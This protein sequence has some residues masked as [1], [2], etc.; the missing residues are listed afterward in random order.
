MYVLS[1]IFRDCSAVFNEEIY[2]NHFT[3]LQDLV[4]KLC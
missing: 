1:L 3:H 2:I 4:I